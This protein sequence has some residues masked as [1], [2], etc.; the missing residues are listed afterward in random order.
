MC[1]ICKK[2][3]IYHIRPNG[4]QVLSMTQVTSMSDVVRH[5]DKRTQKAMK[6]RRT[7]DDDF[8]FAK[9]QVRMHIQLLIDETDTPFLDDDVFDPFMKQLLPLMIDQAFDAAQSKSR[10]WGAGLM[11]CAQWLK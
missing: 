2:E 5:I 10:N 3:K 7:N 11:G 9:E 1:A 8:A 6:G 4:Y